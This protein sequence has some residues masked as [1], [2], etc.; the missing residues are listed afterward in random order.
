[1]SRSEQLRKQREG[2]IINASSKK[3]ET[4]LFHALCGVENHINECFEGKIELYHQP[5]WL[6]RDIVSELKIERSQIMTATRG[7]LKIA[8]LQVTN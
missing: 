3:Q 8:V 6:I 5:Q 2:T 7:W 1:M 4:D